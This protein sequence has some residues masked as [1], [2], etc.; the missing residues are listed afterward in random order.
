MIQELLALALPVGKYILAAT[1]M[2]IF[3]WFLFREKATFN[4]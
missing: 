1:L 3:Y 2:V 4:N